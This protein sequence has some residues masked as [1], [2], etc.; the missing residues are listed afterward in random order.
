MTSRVTRPS[1]STR[2]ARG[3]QIRAVPAEG[4]QGS[5]RIPSS[6]GLAGRRWWDGRGR[7]NGRAVEERG[8][9]GCR[10]V[11]AAG[12]GDWT[13]AWGATG[14]VLWELSD[15]WRWPRNGGGEVEDDVCCLPDSVGQES[16]PPRPLATDLPLNNRR[17]Q[18]D[19]QGSLSLRRALFEAGMVSAPGAR[20]CEYPSIL[21]SGAGPDHRSS[22]NAR[23]K[24]GNPSGGAVASHL[25]L[26]LMDGG[27][28][29]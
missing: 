9:G 29:M 12:L 16:P 15:S 10:L 26:L 21:G 20:R 23:R 7:G 1:P 19:P 22:K 28:I 8:G 27:G 2:I 13:G 5:R 11:S 25:L 4:R 18:P 14:M 24:Q 6:C 17:G 3:G